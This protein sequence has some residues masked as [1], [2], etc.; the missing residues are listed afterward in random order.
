MTTALC[1]DLAGD[2]V[3]TTKARSSPEDIISLPASIWSSQELR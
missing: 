1:V 2:L 3:L